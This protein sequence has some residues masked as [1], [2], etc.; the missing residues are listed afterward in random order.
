M[1][2]QSTKTNATKTNITIDFTALFNDILNSKTKFDLVMSMTKNG[3]MTTTKP[4]TT[5]NVND[6]YIQVNN[7]FRIWLRKNRIDLLGLNDDLTALHTILI[8]NGIKCDDNGVIE[9]TDN[10]CQYRTHRIECIEKTVNAFNVIM[11]YLVTNGMVLPT[12]TK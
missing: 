5:N 3:Y 9:K 7:G 2:N 11:N 4:T 8:D 6:L 1:K 12:P 10:G